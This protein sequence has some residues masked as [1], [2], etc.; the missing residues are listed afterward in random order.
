M[1]EIHFKEVFF[2][3]RQHDSYGTF[4]KIFQDPLFQ[5][6]STWFTMLFIW[7][8]LAYFILWY[9][10]IKK[11]RFYCHI[12]YTWSSKKKNKKNRCPFE[13]SDFWYLKRNYYLYLNFILYWKFLTWA[14][15]F[16]SIGPFFETQTSNIFFM[17]GKRFLKFQLIRLF[18]ILSIEVWVNL[19]GETCSKWF[20]RQLNFQNKHFWNKGNSWITQWIWEWNL[21]FSIILLIKVSILSILFLVVESKF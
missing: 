1:K 19:R 15:I 2:L 3:L 13:R 11:S 17:K 16:Q 14:E 10:H 6:S 9:I 7:L 8:V 20:F 18:I 21:S 4:V 12:F 5:I